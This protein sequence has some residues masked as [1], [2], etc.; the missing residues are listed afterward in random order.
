MTNYHLHTMSIFLHYQI[1]FSYAHARVLPFEY[2]SAFSILHVH[3]LIFFQK[4]V[5]NLTLGR[6][7]S[8]CM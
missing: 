4:L 8:K 2:K 3:M 5:H 1:R 6:S 7:A